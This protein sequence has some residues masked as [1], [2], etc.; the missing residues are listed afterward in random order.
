MAFDFP[1]LQGVI[2]LF[3]T[4]LKSKDQIVIDNKY[5]ANGRQSAMYCLCCD[6]ILTPGDFA[7]LPVTDLFSIQFSL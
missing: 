2:P 4:D 6:E 5:R 3:I 1:E 7:R